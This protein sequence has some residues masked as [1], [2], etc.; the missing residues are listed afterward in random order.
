MCNSDWILWANQNVK[1]LFE[2]IEAV[3]YVCAQN[4]MRQHNSALCSA[5]R[6]FESAKCL[7]VSTSQVVWFVFTSTTSSHRCHHSK[8]I[9]ALSWRFIFVFRMWEKYS[10]KNDQIKSIIFNDNFISMFFFLSVSVSWQVFFSI[11][12]FHRLTIV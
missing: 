5:K 6:T 11:Y 9:P 10:Q 3:F 2:A 4:E 7:S 12:S 8:W 1:L